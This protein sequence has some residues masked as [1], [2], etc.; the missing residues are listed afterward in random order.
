MELVTSVTIWVIH[1]LLPLPRRLC[2]KPAFVFSCL[3]TKQFEK[4][5]M[6]F[7]VDHGPRK[8]RLNVSVLGYGGTLNF[9]LLMTESRKQPT[10]FCNLVLLLVIVVRGQVPGGGERRAA[11]EEAPRFSGLPG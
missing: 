1:V 3:L 8:G 4:L 5:E 2:D 7:H 9:D 11:A 6:D 10:V